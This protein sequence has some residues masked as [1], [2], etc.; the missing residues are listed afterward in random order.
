MPSV[1]RPSTGPS[2]VVTTGP[3]TASAAW[4]AAGA[5]SSASSVWRSAWLKRSGASSWMKCPTPLITVTSKPGE[6]L[7]LTSTAVGCHCALM[8]RIGALTAFIEAASS[9]AA[10]PSNRPTATSA[11]VAHAPLVTHFTSSG[12]AP[13]TNIRGTAIAQVPAQSLRYASRTSS[14]CLPSMR[15]ST[16]WRVSTTTIPA[17]VEPSRRA[18]SSATGPPIECPTRTT[19]WR[20]SSRTTAATS[21]PYCATVQLARVPVDSP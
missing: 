5:S 8:A 3:R 10:K 2:A 4:P 6:Y 14:I 16:L 21:S 7:R 1:M 20:P 11:R 15:A 18:A 19:C 12:S 17:T 13:G 9:I